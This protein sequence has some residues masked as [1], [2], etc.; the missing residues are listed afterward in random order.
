MKPINEL[1]KNK[2][3]LG[4]LLFFATAIVVFLVGLFASSII[5]RRSESATLQVVKPIK[6]WEPRN[7][8]WGENY[9]RELESYLKTLTT[10]Y[11]CKHGGSK[12]IDY[13]G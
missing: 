12:M 6:E 3:W 2:P 5:E 9:P 13:L 11:V 7:E 8:V 10:D 1:I 4:W